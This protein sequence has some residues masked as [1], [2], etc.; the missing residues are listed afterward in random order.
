MR[1]KN[2]EE[3]VRERRNWQLKDWDEEV[4]VRQRSMTV[5]E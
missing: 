4:M 3:A 1:K 2:N 5:K